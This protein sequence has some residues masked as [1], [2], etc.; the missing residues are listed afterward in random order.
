MAF[1]TNFIETPKAQ[2]ANGDTRT[3]AI[4]GN[5]PDVK[6]IGSEPSATLTHK[7]LLPNLSL[8]QEYKSVSNTFSK[9][10]ESGRRM[11]PGIEAVGIDLVD[12]AYKRVSQHPG[13][14]GLEMA[15]GLAVGFTGA[16][17]FALAPEFVVAGVVVGVAVGGAIAGKYLYNASGRLLNAAKTVAHADQHTASEVKIAHRSLQQAGGRAT[18]VLAFG[19]WL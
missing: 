3:I 7:H 1:E 2:N 16:V 17:A 19:S 18:D 4:H 12:G 6:R 11:I 10:A 9:I 13:K 8:T 14:V 5:Y 15:G